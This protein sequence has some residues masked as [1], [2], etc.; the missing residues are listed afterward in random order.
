MYNESWNVLGDNCQTMITFYD[1]ITWILFSCGSSLVALISVTAFLRNRHRQIS[2]KS[3]L[4]LF[5][6]AI[7]AFVIATLLFGSAGYKLQVAIAQPYIQQALDQKCGQGV[8]H[9]NEGQF[10][11][12]SGYYW[13]ANTSAAQ[14]FYGSKGWICS[15][16]S[17]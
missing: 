14:C 4:I 10:Y 8:F 16:S 15:C 12:E 9:A 7:L 11:N 13:R 3:L 6:V 1:G 5:G 17:K 2:T